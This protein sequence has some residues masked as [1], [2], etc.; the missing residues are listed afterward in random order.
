MIH[1]TLTSFIDYTFIIED[2]CNNKLQKCQN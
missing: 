2:I 1:I